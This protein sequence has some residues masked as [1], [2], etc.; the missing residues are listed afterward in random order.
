MVSKRNVMSFGFGLKKKKKL[1]R[2]FLCVLQ[3]KRKKKSMKRILFDE[4]PT[5][6]MLESKYQVCVHFVFQLMHCT[7]FCQT[8]S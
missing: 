1:E 2:S 3:N 4:I 8:V 6:S 5:R 7:N